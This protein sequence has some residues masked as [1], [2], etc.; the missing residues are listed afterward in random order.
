MSTLPSR[1]LKEFYIGLSDAEIQQMLKNLSLNSLD[2]LYAH[3]PSETKQFFPENKI[4]YL[5]YSKLAE[6]LESVA[7]KNKPNL[8]FLGDGLSVSA[9]SPI[10]SDICSIRGLT[11][12]YTPYQPERSQG[13][14]QTLWIYQSLLA[15]ITGYNAVNASLY[16]RS[17][18]LFEAM[19]TANRLKYPDA[20]KHSVI[21][22]GGLYPGDLEV[23]KT[24]TEH[25]SLTLIHCPLNATTGTVSLSELKKLMSQVNPSA[26]VFNQIN[27]LGLLESVDEIVDLCKEHEV[28]SIAVCDPLYN[29]AQGLKPPSEFGK[30]QSG[31]DLL[32]AEGQA[33][34]FP[35]MFG[36]PGLGIFAMKYTQETKNNLRATP[37]RFIGKGHD[38]K[39]NE[40]KVIVLST[41]EQHIRRERA[42]SNI[43]S[44]QSF[45]ATAVGASLLEMGPQGHD[46][47]A[48]GA[49]MNALKAAEEILRFDALQL[50]FPQ[51][52]FWNEL[53]ITV[54]PSAV[55]VSELLKQAKA[56]NISL[57]IDCTTRHPN[58]KPSL[59]ISFN[60]QHTTEDLKKLTTFLA[61]FFKPTK[62]FPL[63]APVPEHYFRSTKVQWTKLSASE[64]VNYYKKLG[65]Q[66]LSPDEGI[67]PLGS[68]TMK[69][70]PHINDWAASLEAFTAHHPQEDESF[71][72]GNLEILYTIQEYFKELTGLDAVTTQPVAGA[73]GELVGLKLFQAYHASRNEASSRTLLLIPRS[74]HGTNPATATVAGYGMG[75]KI[76]E[77][78]AD[79]LMNLEEIA[80]LCK[81]EGHRIAGIMITNPNTAGVYEERFHEVAKLIHDVGGLVYMDGANM[82]A[83][84]GHVNLKKLGV[85]AV[86]NNLHK[87]WTI[88]H[89]GGGPGDAIVAVSERLAEFLPGVQIEKTGSVYSTK[90]SP[91]SIGS[92]HRHH[93]NFAH[94]VRC[95]TYIKALGIT[96]ARK[97]SAAAVLSARYLFE[98]LK[99]H[100]PTLPVGG[101]N[102]A[103]MHE[104][105]L[106][107]PEE[108]FAG[109]SKL[110][111][112]KSVAITRVG[113][114]FLDFGFHAPT[115]AFPEPLGL[116]I[117]PTESF[118]LSELE[119]FAKRVIFLGALIKEHPEVL[120]TVPH[121]TP[122][123]RV[124]EVA[125]N[126]ELILSE[127]IHGILSDILPDR[128][129]SEEL[130]SLP[131]EALKERILAA[132]KSAQV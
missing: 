11:T 89:G 45:I 113:K 33:L 94:K 108:T 75:I 5:P 114:L 119:D 70:N 63:F 91:K 46:Q 93:G 32:V 12:A 49:R 28:Y 21:V 58:Q 122:I 7:K 17:T 9:P 96:G 31:A 65:E 61:K 4:D 81:N 72:Q 2:D 52:P 104:F 80:A 77:T 53:T 86:H 131:F 106:T 132:H 125:A 116:M 83:I 60:D 67:Y 73:Q 30:E 82:N 42:T 38:I 51:T 47:R 37:G 115:V 90:K 127:K 55:S 78:G 129:P 123:F 71:V 29:S 8:A 112:N 50:A 13:T 74:A 20:E 10:L 95:Y 35:P 57:G 64:V 1:E 118:T 26:V 3:I 76:L 103:R 124:D 126:K 56:E 59:K 120:L 109:I 24:L 43:C 69:Y 68:C 25:T 14:L 54:D 15:E 130:K 39:G 121:F 87:T 98:R 102:L 62:S 23:L 27:H 40:C 128:L 22:C 41:R 6:H 84:A 16:D 44:N 117:E 97:M 85:D 66:N 79:G 18:C 107:L 36:G 48:K 111:I 99:P 88:P 110:G 19:H 92:F 101:A 105:I 34:G 100:F